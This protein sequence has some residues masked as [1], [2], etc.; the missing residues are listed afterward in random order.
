MSWIFA[1]IAVFFVVFQ[2]ILQYYFNNKE[3]EKKIGASL[4]ILT[5]LTILGSYWLQQKENIGLLV[6]IGARDGEIEKLKS[7]KRILLHQIEGLLTIRPKL[8]PWG[9]LQLSQWFTI[10]SDFDTGINKAKGLYSAGKVNEAFEI[11]ETLVRKNKSFG[12]GYYL[13]GV[14]EIDKGKYLLGEKN[15]LKAIKLEIPPEDE[16]WAYYHLGRASMQQKKNDEALKYFEKSLAL[17]PNMEKTKQMIDRLK[18]ENKPV[19]KKVI[20]KS[21]SKKR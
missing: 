15:I 20:K 13:M 10:S 1:I 12:L 14:I 16:T 7:E 9:R 3:L 21:G 17:N 8:D 11:A 19:E 5:A 4:L 2:Y 18:K 6:Q